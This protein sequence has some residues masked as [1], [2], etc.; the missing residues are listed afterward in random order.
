MRFVPHLLM[1][2][3]AI[4]FT[5][6]VLAQTLDQC[7]QSFGDFDPTRTAT[8]PLSGET[9]SCET[10]NALRVALTLTEAERK[11]LKNAHDRI[12]TFRAAQ[13]EAKQHLDKEARAT[14]VGAVQTAT[15]I[16]AATKATYDALY[17]CAL[18]VKKGKVPDAKECARRVA[19]ADR[20]V[21][22]AIDAYYDEYETNKILRDQSTKLIEVLDGKIKTTDDEVATVQDK[23]SAFLAACALVA[24]DCVVPP[25][26][27]PPLH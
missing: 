15:R 11:Q 20:S 3:L 1:L 14:T 25:V 19:K 8:F 7:N 2:M 6:G 24:Q 17:E 21:G 12:A 16:A 18:K 13:T 4:A 22:K 27:A 9:T 23:A 26:A 5:P 10:L